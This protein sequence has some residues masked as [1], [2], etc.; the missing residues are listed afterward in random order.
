MGE[1]RPQKPRSG[2]KKT[3]NPWAEPEMRTVDTQK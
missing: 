1:S 2:G 3:R